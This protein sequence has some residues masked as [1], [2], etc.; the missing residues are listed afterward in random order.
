MFSAITG[1]LAEHL[2]TIRHRLRPIEGWSIVLLHALVIMTAAWV[3]QKGDWVDMPAPLPLAAS[4]GAVLGYILAKTRCPDVLAHAS[5]SLM[6]LW[7]VALEVA[8]SYPELGQGRRDRVSELIRRG[9]EWYRQ[10]TAGKERDDTI[11]FVFVLGFTLWL[12]S[13]LSA[14]TL[15][16]R[17]WLLVSLLLPGFLVLVMLGYS[18]NL[19]TWPLVVY[20]LVAGVL[21]ARYFAFRRQQVWSR[22]QIPS[23]QDLPLRFLSIGS[24]MV[25]VVL[26]LAWTL[27]MT[28]ETSFAGRIQ[29]RVDGQ[30]HSL[31]ARWNDL[32][33]DL[34][35][36]GANTSAS[37]ASFSD[38][39]QL[40]GQ[41]SLSNEPALMFRGDEPEYLIGLRYDLYTGHGWRSDVVDTF[42]P[43]GPDGTTFS[44]QMKFQAQQN[45]ELSDDVQDGRSQAVGT[46]TLLRPKDSLLFTID[47]Y[48][49]SELPTSV[50][51]SWRQLQDVPF[52]LNGD[53]A[54]PVPPD[55][56]GMTALLMNAD[57]FE[58]AA[59][60]ESSPMPR[61]RDYAARLE[62]ER[63]QL[64]QRFLDTR[65]EVDDEGQI[66]L[67]VTGQ[68]PVYDDVEAVFASPPPSINE[69]YQVVGLQ[70]GAAAADLRQAGD[71]Y[72]AYIAARYLGL[73]D[74]VTQRTRDLA[75][76]IVGQYDAENPFDIAVAIQQEVRRTI[77]YSLNIEPPPPGQDVVDYVLFDSR[78][79]YCEYHA[80]AMAVLLRAAGVP[81]RIV[82]GYHAVPFDPA[83]QSFVY[84]ESDAHAWVEA[85]FPGYGWIPFEPTPSEPVREYGV[86]RPN[87][88]PTPEATFAPSPTPEPT[89]TVAAEASPT[90]VLPGI[91]QVAPP[92]DSDGSWVGWIPIV[93]FG[94]VVLGII[95]VWAYWTVSLRGLSPAAGLLSRLA[96][97]G[98]WI[99]VRA[100]PSMTPRELAAEI[101]RAVPAARQP[102]R[103]LA[104][105]YATER[106]GERQPNSIQEQSGRNAWRQLRR[107]LFGAVVRRRS[108]GGQVVGKR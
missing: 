34:G 37:Y 86:T 13:Y 60:D 100:D 30:I 69:S 53:G 25:V 87:Q 76:S 79:G 101:G 11:L 88:S 71:D 9:E 63:H 59:S 55:L 51:L 46:V 36:I 105:L 102:A 39:F 70:S 67:Y 18:P 23:P 83:S 45:V 91:D 8:G 33:P 52:V 75:V 31:Q 28:P 4:L 107:T 68:L 61:D 54:E 41:L 26:L 65:W 2:D 22:F 29:D 90:A 95:G 85:Y 104:D 74:S 98:G 82:V 1:W 49:R 19:D 14:W 16:R 80:S 17:R 32:L 64:S 42:N 103:Y 108:R 89:A 73:P 50:Q 35:G 15:F 93:G 6:G 10:T 84:R 40:G 20:L 66:T 57:S 3:V 38:S 7:V 47:T 99:G 12:V 5:A 21:T 62:S 43:S 97:L 78:I 81:S 96:R 106:Y 92:A 24:N 44:P 48:L 58:P 27:P 72:P 94:A 56:R 77:R